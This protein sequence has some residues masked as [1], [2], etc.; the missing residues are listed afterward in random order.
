MTGAFAFL[1]GAMRMLAFLELDLA[2]AY[3]TA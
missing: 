3:S 2:L 1:S